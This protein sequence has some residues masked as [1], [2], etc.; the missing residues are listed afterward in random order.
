LRHVHE[1][2][3]QE[4]DVERHAETMGHRESRQSVVQPPNLFAGVTGLPGLAQAPGR[5]DGHDLEPLPTQPCCIAAGSGAD[6]QGEQINAIW[7]EF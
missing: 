4:N 1:H 2:A 7:Q 6:V 5:F 3:A